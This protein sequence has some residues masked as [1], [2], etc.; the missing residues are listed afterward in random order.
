M[1]KK[2][3]N[4]IIVVAVVAV[5][6]IVTAAVILLIPKDKV[7][8]SYEFSVYNYEESANKTVSVELPKDTWFV[9]ET[10]ICGFVF[11]SKSSKQ[12]VEDFYKEYFAK[13]PK[14]YYKYNKDMIGYYNQS[15]NILFREDLQS[16]TC[17]DGTTIFI[18]TYDYGTEQWVSSPDQVVS[19]S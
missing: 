11:Q 5:I 2:K 4:I 18:I 13:Y 7:I 14:Y 10:G 15:D 16:D 19:D 8:S 6:A 12:E 17:E 3:R 9:R 1:T